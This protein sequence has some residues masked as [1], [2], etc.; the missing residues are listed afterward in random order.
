MEGGM[1]AERTARAAAR[2]RA[3]APPRSQAFAW[4]RPES[5]ANG[6]GVSVFVPVLLGAGVLLSGVAWVVERLGHLTAGPVAERRL[7]RR[8][9]SLALPPGG[10]LDDPARDPFAPG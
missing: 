1:S 3:V 2:I 7:V 9:D 8:L 10:F 4:L 5:V 6:R